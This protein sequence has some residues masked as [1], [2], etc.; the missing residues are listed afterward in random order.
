MKRT[1]LAERISAGIAGW[2]QQ[3][4][5][6]GLEEDV[7]EDAAKV[8]IVRLISA[9]RSFVPK[10]AQRPMNWPSDDR[11]RVDI[12]I[13]GRSAQAANWHGVAE[14]K[15]A[16][17]NADIVKTRRDIV[18]DALRV[19]FTATAHTDAHF[20][21]VG[22]TR[23]AI[24]KLFN[25]PHRDATREKQRK[26][27]KRLFRLDLFDDAQGELPHQRLMRRFPDCRDRVPAAVI[28]SWNRRLRTVLI[29]MD[30]IHVGKS[31]KGSV[32]V[33]QIYR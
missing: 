1:Q 18:Q 21:I 14:V 27:F 6:Q 24:R 30:E 23:A 17:E 11:K 9:Q 8:E 12:A 2:F 19:A 4:A 10:T 31:R 15:W 7:G 22:G 16:A 26:A 5:A 32:Y 28:G 25:R 33:W 3:L 20:L 29:S 13:L